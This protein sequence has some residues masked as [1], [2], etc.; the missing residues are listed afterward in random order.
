MTATTY[1]VRVSGTIPAEL[2]PELDDLT[3][4]V[5]PP[6]TVLYGSVPDQSALFALLSR[7]HGMNLRLL[8][9]RRRRGGHP[10]AKPQLTADPRGRVMSG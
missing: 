10:P 1:R 8:E 5:E 7:I 6:E 9:I 3:I 2:L 4:S